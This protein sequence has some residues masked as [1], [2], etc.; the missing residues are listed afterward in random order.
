MPFSLMSC[1]RWPSWPPSCIIVGS[2]QNKNSNLYCK[3]I[4]VKSSNTRRRIYAAHECCI[5]QR[6]SSLYY[7]FDRHLDHHLASFWVRTKQKILTS[8]VNKRVNNSNTRRWLY[9]AH[10]CCIYQ[11][12]SSL[13]YDFGG[14]LDHH[15]AFLL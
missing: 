6:T 2:E 9:A 4:K 3:Q 12:T 1:L 10:E 14:H 7:D 11:R 15:L 5:Y 8:T 13:Y